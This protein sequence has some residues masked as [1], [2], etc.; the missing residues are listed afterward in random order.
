MFEQKMKTIHEL[1]QYFTR[2]NGLKNKVLEFVMNNPDIILEPSVGQGDLIEIM[3]NN[4]SNI[5]FDMYEIDT[6]IKMLD[7]IP[8]NVIYGDF[9]EANIPKKYKTIIGNPLL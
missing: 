1:G 7:N 5:Q 6:N 4:N 9:M 8:K 2:D 3:Y